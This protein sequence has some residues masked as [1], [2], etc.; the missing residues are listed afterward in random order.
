[1]EKKE[2]RNAEKSI[3]GTPLME[4]RWSLWRGGMNAAKAMFEQVITENFL[5]LLKDIKSP[6]QEVF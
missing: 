6:I 5:K 2:V 4:S 1:M 3:R